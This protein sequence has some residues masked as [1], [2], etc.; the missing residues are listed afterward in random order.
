MLAPFRSGVPVVIVVAAMLV[1]RAPPSNCA[2]GIST[3]VPSTVAVPPPVSETI[4]WPD[5]LARRSAI[6]A[7]VGAEVMSI[8]R[9]RNRVTGAPVLLVNFL[10]IVIVPAFE[11]LPGSAVKSLT[12]LGGNV[13]AVNGS[14]RV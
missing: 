5:V 2:G 11:L 7:G 10:L 1:L 12:R 8:M 3:V 13:A 9:I 14:T 6:P 4:T